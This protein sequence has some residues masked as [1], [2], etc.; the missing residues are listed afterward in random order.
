MF[1]AVLCSFL[2]CDAVPEVSVCVCVMQLGR[3]GDLKL[4]SVRHFILDEC[5]K[6]L[7]K[8]GALSCICITWPRVTVCFQ[9]PLLLSL[10]GLSCRHMCRH[11]LD[12]DRLF[13]TNRQ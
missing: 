1:F 2:R 12:I 8:L 10:V 5:D 9:V 4:G 11:T 7:D 13:E 3:N 6:M